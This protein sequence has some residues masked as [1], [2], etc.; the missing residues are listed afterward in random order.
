MNIN[1][2]AF[3]EDINPEA[4]DLTNFNDAVKTLD[5]ELLRVLAPLRERNVTQ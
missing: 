2:T 1:V 5:T 3:M 4:I